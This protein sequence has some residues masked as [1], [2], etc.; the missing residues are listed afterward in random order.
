MTIKNRILNLIHQ[1]LLKLLHIE[2]RLEPW[3]RPQWNYLFREPSA[4]VVQYLVNFRRPDEGLQ[5]AEE[6]IDPDEEE[7]LN[8]IIDLMAD[9]MRS[10]F[11][12]GGYE[13]GG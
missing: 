5:L 7:S 1:F 13:R 4:R 8:K 12:P 9:Q 3:F 6:K 2:R 11:K 10:R